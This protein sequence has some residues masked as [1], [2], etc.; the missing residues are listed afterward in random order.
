MYNMIPDCVV[1]V[2][3]R[4]QLGPEKRKNR[5]STSHNART[6]YVQIDLTRKKP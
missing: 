5:N 2:G 4:S 6:V 1:G 3:D